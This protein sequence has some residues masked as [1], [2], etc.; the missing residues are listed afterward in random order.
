[1]RECVRCH[2]E[3]RS[4]PGQLLC[5][6]C[7]SDHIRSRSRTLIP[8][9]NCGFGFSLHELDNAGMCMECCTMIEEKREQD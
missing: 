9:R 6:S 1:M 7:V 8:C 3:F 2:R 5:D 4:V